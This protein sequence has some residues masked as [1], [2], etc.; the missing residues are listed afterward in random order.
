MPAIAQ[1]RRC[2]HYPADQIVS[3]NSTMCLARFEHVFRQFL[4]RDIVEIFRFFAARTEQAYRAFKQ[5]VIALAGCGEERSPG[6][7]QVEALLRE[8]SMVFAVWR[9]AS[10]LDGMGVLVIRGQAYLRSIIRDNHPLPPNSCVIE[11]Q[12]YVEACALRVL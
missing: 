5:Q 7:S 1:A 6:P 3:S 10:E 4:F 11:C 12:D 8:G 9:S 2:H